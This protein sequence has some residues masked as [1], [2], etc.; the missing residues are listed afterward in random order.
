VRRS[1]GKWFTTRFTMQYAALVYSAANS[2]GTNSTQW[3]AQLW[4]TTWSHRK[5]SIQQLLDKRTHATKTAELLLELLGTAASLIGC[6][7]EAGGTLVSVLLYCCV[8]T[9]VLM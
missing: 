7:P 4:T 3:Q 2:A 9:V 8:S 6:N 5:A 1:C